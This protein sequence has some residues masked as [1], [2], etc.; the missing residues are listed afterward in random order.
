MGTD[1]VRCLLDLRG[2]CYPLEPACGLFQCLSGCAA[3]E[4]D[5]VVTARKL[6]YRD[7]FSRS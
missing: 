2:L 6:L 7:G 5:L 1:C 3:R 4:R